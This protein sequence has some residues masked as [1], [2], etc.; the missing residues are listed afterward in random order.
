MKR[1]IKFPLKMNGKDI[2][3]L[4]ELRENF[5][6][7]EVT[8]YYM[9]GRLAKWLKNNDYND[10]MS[11][12]L[13]LEDEND[14]KNEVIDIFKIED[15]DDEK[16]KALIKRSKR[17]KILKQY[18][19]DKEIINKVDKI[20]FNQYELSMRTSLYHGLARSI[21]RAYKTVIKSLFE[22]IDDNKNE[23]NDKKEIY[24]CGD[25]FY[26]YD[27]YENVE[28]IG[29]NKPLLILGINKSSFESSNEDVENEDNCFDNKIFDT[30]NKKISFK[31]VKLTS[32]EK[33]I[34]K[35]ISTKEKYCLE[36]M[37]EIDKEKIVLAKKLKS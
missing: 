2:R 16:V 36:N 33:I 34:I 20:I 26:I 1:K 37:L 21:V 12:I 9:D 22:N 11:R 32:K 31:N 25:E 27:S 6:F 5:D 30:V 13:K 24:L 10:E 3:T 8:K 35:T 28:Y 15:S 4:E 23:I 7:E 19:N 18:T 14:L 29:I 17:I